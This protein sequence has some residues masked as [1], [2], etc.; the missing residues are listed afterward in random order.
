[1]RK[2]ICATKQDLYNRGPKGACRIESYIGNWS[3]GKNFTGDH[4]ADD[5]SCPTGWCAAIDSRSHNDQEQEEGANCLHSDGYNP[6]TTCS[7]EEIG[8]AS[9]RERV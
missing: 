7:V 5:E 6:A 8:R 1:M 3:K 9:C 2:V 4:Q